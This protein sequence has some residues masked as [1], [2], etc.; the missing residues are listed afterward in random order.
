MITIILFQSNMM[1][2]KQYIYSFIQLFCYLY[3]IL[4]W[5]LYDLNIS[6]KQTITTS[7]YID[8]LLLNPLTNILN[9]ACDIL[10]YGIIFQFLESILGNISWVLPLVV[11]LSGEKYRQ[12]YNM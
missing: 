3:A 9:M 12:M 8:E 1:I 7:M 2:S 11:F 10:V 4:F 6:R 5:H